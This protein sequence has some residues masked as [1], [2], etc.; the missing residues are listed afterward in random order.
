[1]PLVTAP[2]FLSHPVHRSLGTACWFDD[3][4]R[5]GE[6]IVF[7]SLLL[8]HEASDSFNGWNHFESR[9]ILFISCVSIVERDELDELV[10]TVAL[11]SLWKDGC[12]LKQSWFRNSERLFFQT[13]IAWKVLRE[14]SCL[15]DARNGTFL[16]GKERT[17]KI[18]VKIS[19]APPNCLEAWGAHQY[20]GERAALSKVTRRDCHSFDWLLERATR[21]GPIVS[22]SLFTGAPFSLPD[23]PVHSDIVSSA[24]KMKDP[25]KGSFDF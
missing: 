21:A 7:L 1:M 2:L 9:V 13:S 25:S 10:T 3:R 15:R 14:K 5:Q 11:V 16:R 4:T 22:F 19:E 23:I 18:S 17:V 6:F 20:G 12:V 24:A 8:D